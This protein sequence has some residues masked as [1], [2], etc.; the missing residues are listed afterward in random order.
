MMRKAQVRRLVYLVFH[1]NLMAVLAF[2]MV[3][4]LI[5]DLSA[6]T[7][8]ASLI[9]QA[10]DLVI[11]GI[12]AAEYVFKLLVDESPKRFLRS[13]WRLLD[14]TLVLLAIVS[15]LPGIPNMVKR[16]MIFRLLRV[17]R[18]ALFAMKGVGGIGLHAIFVKNRFYHVIAAT[19]VL[20]M[21]VSVA[22]WRIEVHALMQEEGQSSDAAL[23]H[24]HGDD[25][26]IH[27]LGQ[28]LWWGAGCL[29]TVGTEK[30]TKSAAGRFL[31]V[32]LMML[33]IATMGI[34]TGNVVDYFQQGK[35]PA[36]ARPPAR[37]HRHVNGLSRG[38]G[39][40]AGNPTTSG[41]RGWSADDPQSV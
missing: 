7:S 24:A 10:I 41:S 18:V 35:S 27:T 4:L 9:T 31:G 16:A 29:T 15:Y 12:F 8:S 26:H 2:A 40:A 33:G 37:H 21:L 22:V 5:A 1:D 28:A 23:A 11:V 34:L 17:C 13:P 19:L 38:M 36:P 39:R 3:P 20:A 6:G 32:L 14:L 30:T 25:E